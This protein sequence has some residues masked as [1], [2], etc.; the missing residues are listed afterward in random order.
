MEK[1]IRKKKKMA[2][3]QELSISSKCNKELAKKSRTLS[4]VAIVPSK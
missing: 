4:A 3:K 1:R 2:G